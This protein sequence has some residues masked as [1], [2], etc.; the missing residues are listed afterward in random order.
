MGR[1]PIVKRQAHL[2]AVE[3]DPEHAIDRFPIAA[4]SSSD[5]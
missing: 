4:S 3:I 5:G 2:L 1:R